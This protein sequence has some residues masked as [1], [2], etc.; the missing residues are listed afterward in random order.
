MTKCGLRTLV[1]LALTAVARPEIAPLPGEQAIRPLFEGADLVCFCSVQSVGALG[2][3][4]ASGVDSHERRPIDAV[5]KVGYSYKSPTANPVSVTVQTE[6]GQLWRG[7]TAVLFLKSISSEVYALA[8]PF[9]GATP[10]S[11]MFRPPQTSGLMGLKS[12]LAELLQMPGRDDQINAM[13]LLQGFDDLD[14]DTSSRLILLSGSKDPDIALSALAVL[15]KSKSLADVGRLRMYLAGYPS[16][17]GPIAVTSIGTE[18]SQI[19]NSAAI[20]DLEALT[21]SRL[22]SIRIGSMQ[23]LRA[24]RNTRAARAFVGRI[25]RS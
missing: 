1:V 3:T 19:R 18:L 11:S 12:S 23:A 5:V 24:M 21:D 16:D 17:S 7:E 14:A 6:E 13:K 2:S 20:P 25:G 10:F 4:I 9:V 22:I 15:V 8:D